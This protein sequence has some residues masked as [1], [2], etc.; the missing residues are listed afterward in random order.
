MG[1]NRIIT[2]MSGIPYLSVRSINVTTENV[3][4]NLG[5]VPV[6]PVGYITIRVGSAI[7]TG[8]TGT[9]PIQVSLNRGVRLLTTFG[10]TAVTVADIAGTGV[11]TVFYDSFNDILQLV[12]P[13]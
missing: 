3:N 7:P 13:V 10:G 4:L 1:C 8:T 6:P 9:L 12:S 2:N 11:L 5:Y